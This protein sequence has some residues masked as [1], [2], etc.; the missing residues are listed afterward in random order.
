M[1]RFIYRSLAAVSLLI[2]WRAVEVDGR[3]RYGGTLRVEMQEV[4]HSLDPAEWSESAP[5]SAAKEKLIS[6]LYEPLVR[7]DENG[8]PQAALALSWQHDSKSRQWRFHLR[9]DV[10][11]HDGSAM[12]PEAVAA[13]LNASAPEWKAVAQDDVLVIESDAPMPDLLFDLAK[14]PRSIYLRSADK[15]VFGT[16]PFQLDKW[17]PGRRAVFSANAHHWAGRPF[18]DAV[19]IE[20]GR[21]FTEQLMDLELGKAD[22]VEIWPNEMRRLPKGT[23]VWSSSPHVLIALVFEDG[24]PASEDG[25]LREALA[26]SIDRTA[27]HNWLMQKQ[28][29]ITAALLPQRLSGYAFLFSSRT[30]I[31]AAR[32]LVSKLGTSVPT[33]LLAYDAFDPLARS[34]ADR[35]AVNAREAGITLNVSSQRQNADARLVRQPIRTPSPG[36]AL[37]DLVAAFHLN[38]VGQLPNAA[39]AEAIYATENAVLGSYRIIPLFHVPEIFGSSPRLK[40]WTTPGI[41]QFGGWRF[42]DMWLDAEKP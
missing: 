33:L 30:D 16:G 5:E 4:V 19:A 28:G 7:L 37:A 21:P 15:K 27:M 23:K 26:L 29:E 24:R 11:F 18:L 10:K 25:R 13:A 8:R 39:P 6:L 20:M 36:P 14:A 2:C 3:P 38:D 17:E 9:T 1:Q 35:V 41:G 40:T 22:L 34:I 42:D 31:K 32:Q 12:T